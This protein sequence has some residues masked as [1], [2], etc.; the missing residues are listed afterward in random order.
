[1]RLEK[2][3]DTRLAEERKCVVLTMG[4]A[5]KVCPSIKFRSV[6]LKLNYAVIIFLFTLLPV[7]TVLVT[8]F[9]NAIAIRCLQP[10]H[11]VC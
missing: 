10:S 9:L 1:M 11:R 2:E 3:T 5:V 8:D 4:K 7:I 6:F